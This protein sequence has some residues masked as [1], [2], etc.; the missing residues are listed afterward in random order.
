MW[1]ASIRLWSRLVQGKMWNA[2]SKVTKAKSA[3]GMA[4]VVEHLLS[5]REALNSIP[6]TPLTQS[7]LLLLFF[8]Q[9][10][11]LLVQAGLELRSSY[12]FFMLAGLQDIF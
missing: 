7:I 8:R 1:E 3:V 12:L 5:K 2:I 4:Q 6:T 10:L 9:G 11:V